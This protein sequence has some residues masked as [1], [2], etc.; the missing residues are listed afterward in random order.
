MEWLNQAYIIKIWLVGCFIPFS[1][2]A[3]HVDIDTHLQ[4][5]LTISQYSPKHE[6]IDVSSFMHSSNMNEK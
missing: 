1:F 4:M 3:L 6:I 2:I 5:I